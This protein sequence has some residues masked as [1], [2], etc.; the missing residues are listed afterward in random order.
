MNKKY[1][2]KFYASDGTEIKTLS[3][4]IRK[5]DI[6]FV[7]RINGGQGELV[8][9]LCVDF[10]KSPTWTD[11]NNYVRVFEISDNNLTGGLIYT[12]FISRRIPYIQGSDVGV[13]L[14]ILGLSYLL[15]HGYYKDGSDWTVTW[16]ASD[17]ADMVKGIIDHYRLVNG[18]TWISNDYSNISDVGVSVN[19]EFNAQKWSQALNDCLSI[20][21][22]GYYW[23]VDACGIVTFKP[24]ATTATHLLKY[25]RHIDRA[26]FPLSMEDVINDVTV[27]Y[28]TP[29]T[30]LNGSDVGSINAY[31]RRQKYV[32][33]N[34]L[35][36]NNAAQQYIDQQLTDYATPKIN[37]DIEINA[38]YDYG[39]IMPGECI[40]ILNVEE[41][42][43][44]FNEIMQVVETRY[45]SQN[46]HIT[47]ESQ[48]KNI[49]DEIKNLTK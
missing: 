48:Y 27:I 47:L 30:E 49:S 18:G 17:P 35:L 16:T 45:T 13:R 39:S 28:G 40:T 2:I 37:G 44:A 25:K 41:G 24:K 29:A 9:D 21:G 11:V 31:G 38:L 3:G 32:V 7:Q 20:A 46:L 8:L 33:N 36:D 1:N 14:S 22:G 43:N 26:E 6:S 10:S 12:G 34:S 5:N 19:A 15:N 4:N 23:Y 42:Q